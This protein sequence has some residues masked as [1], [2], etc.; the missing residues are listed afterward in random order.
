[1]T[2][3]GTT[4]EGFGALFRLKFLTAN[5]GELTL[6]Y[7]SDAAHAAFDNCAF[8]NA[9]QIVFVEDAGEHTPDTHKN[10]AAH[11]TPL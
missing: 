4:F 2:Q 6:L 11:K 3:A 5:S 1:L 8:W 9:N 7:R 10:L